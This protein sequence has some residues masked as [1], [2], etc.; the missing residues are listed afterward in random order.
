[1]LEGT[2]AGFKVEDLFLEANYGGPFLFQKT[3]IFLEGGI[4]KGGIDLQFVAQ[5]G[6][7]LREVEGGKVGEDRL[8]AIGVLVTVS[9][10]HECHFRTVLRL[11]LGRG[12]GS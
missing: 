4:I 7:A 2:V 11:V 1:M 8:V 6:S 10:D 9:L 5:R 3:G 12:A